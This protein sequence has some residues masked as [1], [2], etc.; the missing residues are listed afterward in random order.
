MLFRSGM[1]RAAQDHGI[2]AFGAVLDQNVTLDWASDTI[3]T[4]FV[5]D[6]EKSFDMA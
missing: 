6:I 4:S 1:I 5:L 3:L 2:Y